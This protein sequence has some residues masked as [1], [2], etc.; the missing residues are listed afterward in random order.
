LIDVVKAVKTRLTALVTSVTGTVV[1][2]EKPSN[3]ATYPHVVFNTVSSSFED[4]AEEFILEVDIWDNS[5][6]TTAI[7]TL[8]QAIVGNG[9]KTSPT[10]LDHYSYTATG[11]A[12]TFY[13]F[14]RLRIPDPDETIRR[15]QLRFNCRSYIR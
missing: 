8:S 10:G 11:L 13:C 15:R 3:R 7:E 4:G 9:S 14:S 6:S 1:Y 2:N 5:Q 12:I